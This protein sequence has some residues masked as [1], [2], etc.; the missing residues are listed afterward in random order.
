MDGTISA[1]LLL[2]RPP[3]TL[4]SPNARAAYRPAIEQALKHVN[5]TKTSRL[6][7]AISVP[8][9]W[10]DGQEPPR[11]DAFE[12]AQ[13]AL[14]QTYSL[15]CATAAS[16]QI[17]LD[18]LGGVD[19]RAFYLLSA[20]EPA[21]ELA[22]GQG[23]EK[24]FSGPFVDLPTLVESRCAYETLLGVQSEEGERLLKSFLVF[25]Q[26]KH[27]QSPD[28]QR[29]PGGISISQSSN[30]SPAT[31]TSD[32]A[33]TSVAVGGTFDHLHVGHKLLLTATALLAE[34]KGSQRNPS[35][36]VHLIIGISGHNLLTNK[37]F[38]AELENWDERQRRVAD[39]LES[40]IVFSTPRRESRKLVRINEHS[41]TAKYVR[42]E[43]DASL[44]I[45][46][47]ELEDPF[48]PTISDEALS[49][50]VVSQETRAGGAAINAKRQ[51]KG[52]TPL[53]IFEIDV[54]EVTPM[55]VEP[56]VT[57]SSPAAAFES[58][59]SSTEI[60]RRIH[61]NKT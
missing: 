47:I 24:P 50:L 10:L 57:E 23:A 40:V 29:V 48:G 20:P 51:E 6:D 60:R 5:A 25:H 52:W 37:R 9:S 30:A 43:F 2:P 21:G 18:C 55:G 28:C 15:I 17:E 58:K 4:S 8:P 33:H 16:Q 27:R 31:P 19:V 32:K 54:L 45:D 13:K 36:R 26:S 53:D 61:E 14:A 35:Q 59:I 44:T 1:L 39:F 38:A 41:S 49:A 3:S 42:V 56:S 12:R 11:T 22:D 7:I 46:Y 34:P